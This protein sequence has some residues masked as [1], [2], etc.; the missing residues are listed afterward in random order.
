M[1]ETNLFTEGTRPHTVRVFSTVTRK[2]TAL[3][4]IE[5]R[6][7]GRRQR[8]TRPDSKAARV[9]AKQEAKTIAARLLLGQ[10]RTVKRTAVTM[11]QAVKAYIAHNS[12]WRP[13][14]V[15]SVT[16]KLKVWLA[17]TTEH[18]PVT[19]VTPELVDDFRRALR[20]TPR[21]KTG[22]PMV[23]AQIARHV[24]EVKRLMRFAK[25][26]K[27]VTENPLAE[28]TMKLG[29][30][31][32]PMEVPEY[33]NA[34]W[35]AL[36][37]ALSYRKAL[38]W[39]PFCCLLLGGIL[40]ARQTALRS[41]RWSD[42]NIAH[43]VVTWPKAFDKMG[44]ERKQPLPR[45]A[46]FAL[47]IA[48][49][50]RVRSRYNGEWVFFGAQARTRH[51][52]WTEQALNEAVHRAEERAGVV[53]VPYRAMHGFRRTSAGNALEMSN[54][55]KTAG[56]WIGDSDLKSLQKYLKSRPEHLQRLATLT[57]RPTAKGGK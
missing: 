14:M 45:D 52:P 48:K 38:E 44:K 26:R 43:R 55:L 3:V 32:Q 10:Q 49:V 2:G 7:R 19:D 21:Q 29:K 47:R 54:N 36:L 30:D 9:W 4:R 42:I 23:A 51:K 39:R 37:G 6:E 8:L 56:E 46:V 13:K 20:E 5:W 35:D 12:H 16:N 17:F 28:Y 11:E 22:K 50:W 15:T 40:G 1:T 31:E 25:A 53:H 34:E 57:S 18:L 27:Y 41:L 33:T 24:N